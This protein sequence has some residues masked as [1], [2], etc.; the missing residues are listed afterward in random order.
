MLGLVAISGFIGDPAERPAIGHAHGERL[1]AVGHARDIE[2]G[3]REYRAQGGQKRFLGRPIEIGRHETQAGK[4]AR[5][6]HVVIVSRR[7]TLSNTHGRVR[8]DEYAWASAVPT[9]R[10]FVRRTASASRDGPWR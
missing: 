10:W 1:A 3:A 4:R 5:G 7:C 6:G 8:M 2:R 9:A